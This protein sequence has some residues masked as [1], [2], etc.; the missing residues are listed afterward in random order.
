M[1]SRSMAALSSLCS[2]GFTVRQ[3]FG[4]LLLMRMVDST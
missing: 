3:G 4:R 2:I 1:P